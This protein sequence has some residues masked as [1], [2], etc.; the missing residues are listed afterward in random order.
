VTG[1]DDICR[2]SSNASI[3]AE[4]GAR[5]INKPIN[6]P[7]VR[8]IGKRGRDVHDIH[9]SKLPSKKIREKY[10]TPSTKTTVIRDDSVVDVLLG[11]CMDVQDS[12]DNGI[13]SGG[14]MYRKNSIVEENDGCDAIN[15]DASGETSTC[16]DNSEWPDR[17][18]CKQNN[19]IDQLLRGLHSRLLHGDESANLGISACIIPCAILKKMQNISRGADPVNTKHTTENGIRMHTVITCFCGDPE[20]DIRICKDM[21]IPQF[22]MYRPRNMVNGDKVYKRRSLIPC[23]L[24]IQSL[25]ANSVCLQYEQLPD[26]G[27]HIR[28]SMHKRFFSQILMKNQQRLCTEEALHPQCNDRRKV[29]NMVH[30]RKPVL[31]ILIQG[32]CCAIL[33]E[34]IPCLKR[35]KRRKES[36]WCVNEVSRSDLLACINILHGTMLKLYPVGTKQPTFSARVNITYR[37]SDILAL[38]TDDQM[39]FLNMYPS[40]VKICFMEYTMNILRDFMPCERK[41][42][43]AP[44][45][46]QLYDTMGLIMCDNFRQDA[47]ITGMESWDD[48]DA[49]A[50]INIEK[51]MRICKFKMLRISEPKIKRSIDSQLFPMDA[52]NMRYIYTDSSHLKNLYPETDVTTVNFARHIQDNIMSYPLPLWVYQ[53]QLENM[54]RLHGACDTRYRAVK[55]NHICCTCAIN[56]RLNSSKMRMCSITREI[57]CVSCPRGTILKINMLGIILKICNTSYYMCPSC[58]NFTVWHADGHDLCPAFENKSGLHPNKSECGCMCQCTEYA[59]E[60]ISYNTPVHVCSVCITRRVAKHTVTVPNLQEKK[61]QD[62]HFCKRHMPTDHIM[63]HVFNSI[64]LKHAVA[65]HISQR[66]RYISVI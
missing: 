40:L 8:I 50:E 55:Y 12:V 14:N 38:G 66:K 44:D 17:I 49:I 5:N 6:I 60:V 33:Q 34:S 21:Y 63:K 31:Q 13:N 37:L 45:V 56:N 35:A 19:C 9:N 7:D 36:T 25:F 20:H 27:S 10:T 22:E 24:P 46:V 39:N 57:N 43:L 42:L 41:V 54:S 58:T 51:C 32:I 11:A 61:I 52:L 65:E 15:K 2:A 48:M 3:A 18:Y 4:G 16:H 53:H 28:A 26:I 23:R 59:Q 47:I 62:V 29:C 64:D 30:Y 1:I